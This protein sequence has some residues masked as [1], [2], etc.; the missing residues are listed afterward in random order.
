MDKITKETV[1]SVASVA[2]THPKQ[3]LHIMYGFFILAA[4]AGGIYLE[5]RLGKVAYECKEAADKSISEYNKTIHPVIATATN[6]QSEFEAFAK[7][8]INNINRNLDSLFD[9]TGAKPKAP[10]TTVQLR[11][12]SAPGSGKLVPVDRKGGLLKGERKPASKYGK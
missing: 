10:M 4:L 2:E 12:L 11:G 1:E 5:M 3:A 7:L 9:K 6:K 8:Q